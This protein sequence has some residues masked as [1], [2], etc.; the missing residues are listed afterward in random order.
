MVTVIFPAAGLSR[1]MKINTNKNFLELG[2]ESVL[3]RTLKTFSKSARVKNL[4]VVV[5]ENEIAEVE[6]ILSAEKNL[7]PYKIVVGGSERQYSIANG[8]KFLPEDTEIIL[9]HDAARPLISQTVIE[10]VIDAAEKFGGAIA[11]VP[12]KNTIKFVDAE[13]FVK[14]TPPRSELVEVQTPQGFKKD[15]LLRAYKKAEEE[16]FLGTD[17]ASLVERLGEKI[18]IVASDYK[19]IKI[20]TPEDLKIAEAILIRNEELELRNKIIPATSTIPNSSLLTPNYHSGFGYDVHK[21]VEGRKLIL[22]GVEIP[23]TLGLLGHSDADVLTHAIIDALL[24]AATLGDIGQHFPDTDAEFK[25]IDSTKLLSKVNELIQAEGWQ[26]ENIDSTIVAQK[27]KLAPHISKIR[28]KI[29]E[30]L[31]IDLNSVN[32]KAKTEEGLGFTGSQQGISSYAV[33]TLRR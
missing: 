27:P 22:G 13:N 10:N 3:L 16:N 28:Q 6:K 32:V 18:K 23:H 5:A 2:G 14:S 30:V 26:I 15:I 1:R 19:N 20:T 25:D 7:K 33:A 29:S 21:L 11:A 31:Q 17:D 8:L 9:V 4:I 24:G 12:A